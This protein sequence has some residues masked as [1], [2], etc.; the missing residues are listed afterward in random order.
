M[1]T[2]V[3]CAAGAALFALNIAA[4]TAA[5]ETRIA[6]VNPGLKDEFFWPEVSRTMQAAAD[7]FGFS[8]EIVYAERDAQR[9]INLGLAQVAQATPPDILI[10]VNEFQAAPEVLEAADARGI[11]VLMLLNAFIGE[12][13][14]EMDVP[15]R[16][17]PHWIG[18]LVPSNLGAGQ[19]MAETLTECM[20]DHAL[21]DSADKFHVLALA[22]DAR[23][24]A[25]L[26]RTAGMHAGFANAK[27][28]VIDRHF[29]TNWQAPDARRQTLN[30]L[31]WT[32]THDVR[33]SGIWA[34]NDALA[35]G[36]IEAVRERGLKPG[37]DICIVGLNWSPDALTLVRDG[38]MAGTD[39]GHFLAGGW[40]MV[41]INDYLQQKKPLGNVSFEMAGIDRH[42][43]QQFMAELGNRDWRRIPFPRFARTDSGYDFSLTRILTYLSE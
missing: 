23:T 41:M 11:K 3:L 8:L 39:G 29:R 32:K 35:L 33:P 40:A 21:A 43:V 22:G 18:S 30:Y 5:A 28:V 27:S 37:S 16:K 9:M 15:G 19:R 13:L 34:A 25:S 24:P 2:R 12:Q 7:Q 36:A 31:D 42:N 14:R 38:V 10:L 20:A 17:H 26:E 1:L 4:S 6:F